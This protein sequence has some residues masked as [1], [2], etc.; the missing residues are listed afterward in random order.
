M[1]LIGTI[2]GAGGAARQVGEAVGGVAEVFVGNRAERDSDAAG[3][4]LATVAEFGAEFAHAS[5]GRWDGFVNGLNRLPRPM[6]ASARSGSSSTPWRRRP[7]SRRGC[8]GCS[9]CRSR[10]GGSSA[11]SS[12]STSAPASCTTSA[13]APSRGSP[14][15]SP[16]SARRHGRARRRPA[17]ERA[18]LSGSP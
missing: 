13:P 8:R 2:L 5:T 18:G 16:P 9:W 7:A 3:R 12:P 17:R 15:A 11:P 4:A 6:L 14:P 1:G 10:S